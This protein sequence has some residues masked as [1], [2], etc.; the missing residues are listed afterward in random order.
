MSRRQQIL[1]YVRRGGM[2]FK[3]AGKGLIQRGGLN[4]KF[5]KMSLGSGVARKHEEGEGVIKYHNR[6]YQLKD[7]TPKQ[8][9]PSKYTPIHFKL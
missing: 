1:S 7:T 3:V 8:R 9:T 5:R 6:P 2:F 4:D